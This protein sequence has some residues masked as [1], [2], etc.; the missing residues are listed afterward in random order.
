MKCYK[1]PE[2]IFNNDCF[3][4]NFQFKPLNSDENNFLSVLIQ[5]LSVFEKLDSFEAPVVNKKVSLLTISDMNFLSLNSKGKSLNMISR[6]RDRKP[7]L[8]SSDLF[9]NCPGF[10]FE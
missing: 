3:K 5:L 1:T 2:E 8:F 10:W 4:Q 9:V 6:A 7:G